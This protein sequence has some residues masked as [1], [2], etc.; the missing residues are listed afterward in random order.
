MGQS[1]ELPWVSPGA[2]RDWGW[3]EWSTIPNGVFSRRDGGGH[4]GAYYRT[5]P[6]IAEPTATGE[7]KVFRMSVRLNH[8]IVW[9]RDKH[10]SATFLTETLGL[11]APTTFGPFLV[12]DLENGVSLD[13]HETDEPITG[14]H[15]AFL[16]G[17]EEFD[18]AFGRLAAQEVSYWADPQ[19]QR[20]GEVN[21]AD[22][23]RGVYFLD[24]NEHLL[25]IITRP[26]GGG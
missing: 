3:S 17:E 5:T 16:I 11:P 25:E 1:S 19:R 2:A 13:F 10:R 23:G 20:L 4:A 9:C 6:P 24:P 7:R 21:Q 8:T 22:G 14:Q 15:Y 26:Y 18:Q 12:V